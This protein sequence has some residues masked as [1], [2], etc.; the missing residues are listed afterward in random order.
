MKCGIIN[1]WYTN[2]YGAAVT[3]FALQEAVRALGATPHV[4][5]FR[6]HLTSGWFQTAPFVRSFEP[7]LNVTSDLCLSTEDLR[8]HARGFDAY[9]AG[10][11]QI[12]RWIYNQ[13]CIFDNTLGFVPDA[14]KKIACAASFGI[15]SFECADPFIRSLLRANLAR[16]DAISVRE[17]SG[18]EICR[19]VFGVDAVR[20]PD[21]VF[22]VDPAAYQ[23][24]I[25]SVPAPDADTIATYILDPTPALPPLLAEAQA[26]TGVQTVRHYAWPDHTDN[27]APDKP[28]IEAW[29]AGLARAKYIITDSYHGACFAVLFNVPFLCLV[30][31]SRGYARYRTLEEWMG[32]AERFV[33]MD[34]VT[35]KGSS[36][37]PESVWTA[38]PDEFAHANA[39]IAT[40]R[41]SAQVWLRDALGLGN[42]ADCAPEQSRGHAQRTTPAEPTAR[43]LTQSMVYYVQRMSE[44]LVQE[45]ESLQLL[46]RNVLVPSLRRTR[47]WY[48][49]LGAI[50]PGRHGQRWRT[51]ALRIKEILQ[52]IAVRYLKNSS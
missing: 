33:D 25:N 17:Q 34:A 41:A 18:V 6:P 9:I 4:I 22:V 43:E 19:E 7:R 28:T 1:L 49:V 38:R 37:L 36:L 35:Q 8:Q 15:D 5:N 26:R 51:K 14:A 44:S 11:D 46:I 3:C 32:S 2:N 29:L 52:V 12:L 24:L 20:Q 13:N 48:K 31:K 40:E 50:T 10:S 45:T 27:M 23:P 42:A 39:C 21:P 47:I 30:N 16:F